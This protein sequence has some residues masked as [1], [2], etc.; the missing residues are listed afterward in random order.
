MRHA[1]WIFT[2]N[3]KNYVS[4][5]KKIMSLDKK[6]IISTNLSSTDKNIK[7]VSVR[8]YNWSSNSDSSTLCVRVFI[9]LSFCSSAQKNY[10]L[11]S[12]IKSQMCLV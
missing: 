1:M 9:D 5:Q 11:K 2:L 3:K 6:K 7:I 10:M 12:K 4:W 8:Q